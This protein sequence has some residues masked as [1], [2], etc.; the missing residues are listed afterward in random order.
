MPEINDQFYKE[1]SDS[2]K[3]VFD[4]TS[5]IDERVKH[6]VEQHSDSNQRIERLVE[7]Q[8][9]IF[10][11]ISV[12]ENKNGNGY[13]EDIIELKKNVH[14]ME[15]KMSSLELQTN[16]HENKW[17]KIIDFVFKVSVAVVVAIIV[18]KIGLK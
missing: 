4:L 6:L 13:K 12:L 18:W 14:I 17:Q 3:L 7:R 16:Q 9:D 8:E 10:S 11:R 5:R 15:I 2:I 1:V